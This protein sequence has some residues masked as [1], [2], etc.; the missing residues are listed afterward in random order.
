MGPQLGVNWRNIAI[1]LIDPIR[2]ILNEC[3]RLI[4]TV[5]AAV[6][7]RREFALGGS[8]AGIPFDRD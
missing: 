8:H 6:Q 1:A 7:P 5:N 4:S 2:P 3:D